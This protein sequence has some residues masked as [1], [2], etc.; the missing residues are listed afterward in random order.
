MI[1]F[2]TLLTIPHDPSGG[3]YLVITKLNLYYHSLSDLAFHKVTT[4]SVFVL[5]FYARYHKDI[6]TF[7]SISIA[8][9]AQIATSNSC[10]GFASMI[11]NHLNIINL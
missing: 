10:H 5:F 8:G 7:L 2:D 1:V 4:L 3:I 11:Q 6:L 9:D